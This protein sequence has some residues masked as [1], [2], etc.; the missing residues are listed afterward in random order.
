MSQIAQSLDLNRGKA[1]AGFR[2]FTII[3]FGQLLSVLGS[4]LT[5]FAL[6]VWL[7]SETGSVTLFALGA[8]FFVL[9]NLIVSPFAGVIVDRFDRRYVMIASDVGAGLS[10]LFL[11]SMF[12]NGQLQVWHVYTATV[13]NSI[14][15]AFQWPAFSAATTV[16]VPREHLGRASGMTQ[17]SEALSQLI[18]PAAAGALL[19][20]KDMGFIFMVDFGTLLLAVLT[21]V[22]VR[23]PSPLPVDEPEED[24]Q[25]I[26]SQAG[27]GW[28]YIVARPGLLGLLVF[29]STV[30]FF[31]AMMSP[32]L[33]PMI[34]EFTDEKVLGFL[35]SIVGV[36]MLVGTAVMSVWGGPRNRVHGVLGPTLI[37][38]LGVAMLGLRESIP[39]VAI[40]G[41]MFMFVLPILNGSSQALWQSKVE[42]SLQGRVFTVRRML[43][44]SAAP[45]A[46]VIV[47]PLADHV[48][49]PLM[50]PG[51]LLSDSVGQLIG[52][53]DG[54]G[55]ALLMILIGVML[56]AAT[57]I[58]YLNPRVRNIENEIPDAVQE[59][60]SLV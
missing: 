23:I 55:Y 28:R 36:G 42:A 53:G 58:A 5:G 30:N 17:L 24:K 40:A 33:F 14:C 47:G 7:Y 6:N 2:T 43:A 51:G 16:L 3:W 50:T 44:V 26:W 60:N 31:T 9:P 35:S 56:A 41:F 18:A 20:T 48:F 19:V 32:L 8:L 10:T 34:L 27:F 59:E 12:F 38:A 45:L 52:V 25:S 37:V 46:Y 15:N 11:V 13:I 29:F 22:M 49:E 39:L 57:T 1:K 4:S 54:R 21:L